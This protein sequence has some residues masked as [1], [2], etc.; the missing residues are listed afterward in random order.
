ML[1]YNRPDAFFD[2][3]KTTFI[4]CCPTWSNISKVRSLV[5]IFQTAYKTLATY[6]KRKLPH[7]FLVFTA[8]LPVDTS[9]KEKMFDGF[10]ML[11]K[12][13]LSITNF[14]AEAIYSQT[15]H[16]Y[17]NTLIQ[18]NLLVQTEA[19]FKI[20]DF[21]FQNFDVIKDNIED[22][23]FEALA[24]TSIRSY[25]STDNVIRYL[26]QKEKYSLALS[27]L[28]NT[29]LYFSYPQ[30]L[31]NQIYDKCLKKDLP[32]EEKKKLL[33]TLIL[34]GSFSVSVLYNYY[35]LLTP[36]ER[37]SEDAF[38]S[39]KSDYAGLTSAYAMIAGYACRP[40]TLSSRSLDDFVAL[41]PIIKEKF[42]DTY[43]P[44]LIKAM[45][46]A[47]KYGDYTDHTFSNVIDA[48]KE[49]TAFLSSEAVNK[50]SL[51]SPSARDSYLR[52]LYETKT[53]S[54]D[55]TIHLYGE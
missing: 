49:N 2:Q 48:Y 36:E 24:K 17:V 7:R 6:E 39:E 35:Q 44:Y 4:R 9:V 50:I 29:R 40:S 13:K 31:R 27:V 21:F 55:T 33:R 42:K 51:T 20:I 37:E 19:D 3:A 52:A 10:Y 53:T 18:N 23:T 38:L 28:E 14:L 43:L 25:S 12:N 8:E 47:Y 15:Y 32:P 41:A 34:T 16:D 54:F 30:S 1:Q 11:A 5:S 26:I 46:K 22:S 45:N